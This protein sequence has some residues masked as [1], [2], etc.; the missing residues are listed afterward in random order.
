MENVKLGDALLLQFCRRI[1]QIF[2][3]GCI[4]PNMH[5]CCNL[6]EYIV[7]YGPLRGFWCFSLLNAIMEAMPSNKRNIE[8]QLMQLFLRENFGISLAVADDDE[9]S[10]ELCPLLTKLTHTGSLADSASSNTHTTT[11]QEC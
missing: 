10:R 4:T 1:E 6:Y 2:G 7:D 9:I 3:E 8:P 5:L 11:I